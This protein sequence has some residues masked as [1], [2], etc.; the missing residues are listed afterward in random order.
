MADAWGKISWNVSWADSWGDDVTG[1]PILNLN[2]TTNVPVN[3]VMCDRSG[4]RVMPRGPGKGRRE[5]YGA[6]VRPKSYESVHPMD[7]I[8]SPNPETQRGPKR[9]EQ[10]DTFISGDIDPNDF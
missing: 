7:N 9:P 8:R 10:N 4:F 1:N 2:A 6:L 5:F 3:Y